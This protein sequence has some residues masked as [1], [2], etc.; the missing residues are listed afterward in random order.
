MPAASPPSSPAASPA[1]SIEQRTSATETTPRIMPRAASALR[2]SGA[3]GIITAITRPTTPPAA[4]HAEGMVQHV[5]PMALASSPQQG[6]S[7][8]SGR[9]IDA[10][11]ATRPRR[12]AFMRKDPR[13]SVS[14]ITAKVN[15]SHSRARRP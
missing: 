7:S 11:P 12:A 14:A 15:G 8:D 6:R 10:R 2:P 4:Q 5:V 3:A 9:T 13:H 1:K